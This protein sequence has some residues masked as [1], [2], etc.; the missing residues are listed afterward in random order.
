[1]VVYVA[2]QVS[3]MQKQTQ[4]YQDI[5]ESLRK[6]LK[7]YGYVNIVIQQY[8]ELQKGGYKIGDV[9]G[10]IVAFYLLKDVEE[11]YKSILDNK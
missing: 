11:V 3:E 4:G 2:N 8:V 1:M 9:S 7:K 10:W 6:I 5:L